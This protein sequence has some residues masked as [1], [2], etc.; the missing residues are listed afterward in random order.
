MIV[1]V[2]E[3]ES[4]CLNGQKKEGRREPRTHW[5]RAAP[6]EPCLWK[7]RGIRRHLRKFLAL[8]CARRHLPDLLMRPSAREHDPLL[9][10]WTCFPVFF[11]PFSV[12]ELA[13]S[14]HTPV[15]QAN[16]SQILIIMKSVLSLVSC[17]KAY[18]SPSC[19]FHWRTVCPW[20]LNSYCKL[21]FTMNH[22]LVFFF[23]PWW[24]NTRFFCLLSQVGSSPERFN[25]LQ[26]PWDLL[27]KSSVN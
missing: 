25:H 11:L 10:L 6:L 17:V 4:V 14:G 8:C 9:P 7:I 3:T 21:K 2:W 20:P 1:P 12:L 15:T 16:A 22:P 5:G 19:W 26:L 23:F 13:S 24:E 27:P 18:D